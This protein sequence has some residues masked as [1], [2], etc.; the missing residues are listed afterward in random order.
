MEKLNNKYGDIQGISSMD[1]YKNG[2]PRNCVVNKINELKTNYGTLIPQYDNGSDRRKHVNSFSFYDDGNLKSIYLQN[3]T[4]FNTS[5]GALPGE[6][7][8]FYLNGN[9]NRIFPLN[10]QITAYWSEL[11]EYKLAENVSLNLSVG[12][13]EK[14]VI[15]V[16][17][18]EDGVVKSITLWPSNTV[19]INLP[20]GNVAA[21]IGLSFYNDGNLKSFEPLKPTKIETPIGTITAYDVNALGIHG[22]LNSVNFSKDGSIESLITSS[23]TIEVTTKTGE[24]KS[25]KPGLKT[26]VMNDEVKDVVPMSISF[27][28][29]KVCFN[30]N[31]KDEHSLNECTF[32]VKYIPLQTK[33][34][35]IGCAG[36]SSC[37]GD[38]C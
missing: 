25:Y 23:D 34:P 14:K 33:S 17:F 35:C 10:G 8:T 20:I 38:C 11:D 28:D 1:Y 7:I 32:E 24:K 4:K 2:N 13:F 21:R 36:N 18:Y 22:D 9:I 16:H 6:L 15:C 3:Q 27:N 26:S 19:E 37:D 30:N 31:P 12:K 5:I 29:N